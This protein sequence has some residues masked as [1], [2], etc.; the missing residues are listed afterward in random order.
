M[1]DDEKMSEPDLAVE[2]D[3]QLLKWFPR[4]PE[5]RAGREDWER[6]SISVVKG[7]ETVAWV[8][9]LEVRTAV[10]SGDWSFIKAWVKAKEYWDHAHVDTKT[11]HVFGLNKMAAVVGAGNIAFKVADVTTGK[12]YPDVNRE[13]WVGECPSDTYLQDCVDA[14]RAKL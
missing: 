10:D 14:S 4:D 6:E 5:L 12:E 3:K 1:T 8:P 7:T 13:P 9:Q 11:G 2:L